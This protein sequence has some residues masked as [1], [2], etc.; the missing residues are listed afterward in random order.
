[1]SRKGRSRPLSI[2]SFSVLRRFM[3]RRTYSNSSFGEAKA[4]GQSFGVSKDRTSDSSTPLRTPPPNFAFDN[5][6]EEADL[7]VTID[8]F[9]TADG[10]ASDGAGVAVPPVEPPTDVMRGELSPRC[11]VPIEE[12]FVAVAV[13]EADAEDG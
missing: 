13:A 7:S 12:A 4:V 2:A 10:N 5:S 8:K 11:A 6:R 3:C 1:R 9:V